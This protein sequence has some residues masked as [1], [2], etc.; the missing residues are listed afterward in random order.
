MA[1]ETATEKSIDLVC[2]GSCCIDIIMNVLDVLRFEMVDSHEPDIIKKYTAIEY[3]SKLNV[4]SLK[5]TPGGSAANVSVDLTM[6]SGMTTSYIGKLGNDVFGQVAR[7]ELEKAGV[8]VDSC[9]QTDEDSTALSVILM[10]PLGKDRSILAYKGANNLI[11]PDEVQDEWVT[12]GKNL[13]WTSLTSPSGVAS[14]QKCIDLI[15]QDPAAMVFACPS[16]SIIKNN[17]DAAVNLVKQ[18]DVLMCNKEELFELV[19]E[20]SLTRC[21]KD[22]LAWGLKVIAC[23]NGSNG[24]NITDGQYFIDAGVYDVDV[25]DTTGAGDAFASGMIY[26]LINGFDLETT[27]KY[28]SA[29]SAFECQTMGVREGIPSDLETIRRF[30]EEKPLKIKFLKMED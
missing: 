29:V 20:T 14:I 10:T 15:R 12:R 1:E 26:S 30:I 3:S 28:A 18:S 23:T 9:F 21:F 27:A 25:V 8:N 4:K 17:H 2:I 19:G 24:S 22:A 5:F 13:Q 11:T 6:F 7:R 16:I